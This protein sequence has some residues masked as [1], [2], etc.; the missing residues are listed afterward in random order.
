MEL[1]PRGGEAM[2][3]RPPLDQFPGQDFEI[4]IPPGGP[5]VHAAYQ[6]LRDQ[7]DMVCGPYVLTYLLQAYGFE[8]VDEVPVTVDSVA[9]AAGTALETRNKD[10]QRAV[11]NAI[12]AGAIPDARARTWRPHGHF[13]Y[14]LEVAEEGGCSSE[15]LVKACEIVSDGKLTA[16]P[17]PAVDGETVQLTDDAFD[18]VL[19]ATD[20]LPFPAQLIFNYNLKHTLAPTGLLGHRYNPLALFTQWDD[21]EYFRTLDWDVGHFTSL[22]GRITRTDNPNEYLLIRDSYRSFGSDG[23][24]LQPKAYIREGLVRADDDR[25]GGILLV[26]RTDHSDRLQTYLAEAGLTT[27]LWDNG[28]PYLPHTNPFV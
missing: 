1:P 5:D 24:H 15:G 2:T 26:V 23:Y 27:G 28:S 9:A 20:S 11:E 4:S 6:G 25:D 21:P 10:R 13:D 14:P 12:D 22:A 19:A 18:E 3:E 16:V 17:V 7:K 8:T